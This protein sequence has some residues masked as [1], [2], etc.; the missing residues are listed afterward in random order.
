[1]QVSQYILI[2]KIMQK[3]PVILYI[4]NFH[5]E[6]YILEL[7]RRNPTYFPSGVTRCKTE[8]VP[9]I[10]MYRG[11]TVHLSSLEGGNLIFDVDILESV[12]SGGPSAL[13]H[14]NISNEDSQYELKFR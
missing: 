14:Q 4:L 1:M 2:Q 11:R 6:K 13:N 5:R 7:C 3:N 10:Q 9:S 8:C 12:S